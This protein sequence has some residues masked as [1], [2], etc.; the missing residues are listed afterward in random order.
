[1]AS[2]DSKETNKKVILMGNEALV[3]GAL[4]AGVQFV[5]TYPG[6]PASE[7]GNI[8]AKIA[9]PNDIYFE[10]STNEKVALE[11]AIGASFSGLKCLVAM[12]NFGLNVCSDSLLPFV[13]TGSV[14][15]TVIAVGDD[16]SCWSSAQSEEN[17]RGYAYLAHLPTLEPSDPQ[18]CREFTKL[19]FQISAKFKIPVMVRFTTRVAHQKMPVAL[20]KI[21]PINPATGNF[22]KNPAQFVTMPPRVLAM[23]TELLEKIEKIK[24]WAAKNGIDRLEG[25]IDKQKRG[26]IASSVSYLYV[27]EAMREL[28]LNLPVLKINL[29][30]PLD[31]E[32]IKKYIKNLKEVLVAEELEPYLEK[33]T[34]RLA[35]VTNPKLKIYGKDVLPAVGELRP[36]QVVAAVA[37]LAKKK[38][39]CP[40]VNLPKEVVKRLPNFCPGCYYRLV[41]QAIKKTAPE[42]T[43]YGGDI[44]C[45]M[46]ASLPTYGLADYLSAMGSSI[47]IGHGI[48]KTNNQKVITLIGDSTFFHAGIPALINTV[49][50]KSSPLI[51]V[52]DNQTT[53]MTGHQTN[54]GIGKTGMGEETIAL[55]IE[56]ICR[57]CGVKN[58]KVIDPINMPEME[59]TIKEFLEKEE[60]SVI[61][62]R[63]MCWLLSQSKPR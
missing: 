24:N 20:G 53:A 10:F 6:T 31:E 40:A 36:E 5:A 27:R 59:A 43:I 49:F 52:L 50:N 58:I 12:K 23:K 14:G 55:D 37:K 60:V 21:S 35:K 9:K 46:I 42:G 61:I 57:A 22:V 18:E 39:V 62:A 19:A 34:E 30:Y 16:P 44:G 54:P 1:M 63:R 33:E 32:N 25:K 13:Y 47:G 17:S 26:I 29:F 48:K 28:K 3:R 4:E 51:I 15:P 56:A 8:F 2:I 11:A 41:L 38:Y 45:Y 7:I